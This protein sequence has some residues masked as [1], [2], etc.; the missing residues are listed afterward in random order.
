MSDAPVAGAGQSP[1]AA[2]P[3]AAEPAMLRGSFAGTCAACGAVAVMFGLAVIGMRLTDI[4]LMLVYV[5]VV[6]GLF[7]LWRVAE[8][9]APSVTLLLRGSQPV[10][11]RGLLACAI[12]YPLLSTDSY[13]LH[14]F[15]MAGLFA[16][17]ALGLNI[18]VGFAGLADFGFI[19]YYAIGAYTSALLDTRLGLNVWLC[20]PLAGITAAAA[21]L[22]VS[23]P[24]LRVSG[25]YL[26]LVTL[27]FAFIV[28]Q[29]ITNLDG[30]TGGTQGVFG[31][32]APILFG[33]DFHAPLRLWFVNLP[34]QA[35][36]YYLSLALLTLAAAGCVRLGR[37][38]WGRAWAAMRADEV[39]AQASGLDL[40]RLK[41]IAFATGAGLG[42][43]AGGVY[44]HM[45]GYLDP[46]SF[47]Y[48]DSIILLAMVALGNWRV[49]GVVGAAVLFTILPEKLRAFDDWRL[50][51]FGLALLT[52]ML[53]RG[54]RAALLAH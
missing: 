2:N 6:G 30:L 13:Q 17:M 15:A 29:M 40:T 34:Y 16:L 35:N 51:L 4:R 8:R 5:V 44:A 23:L 14:L 3:E 43:I 26:A 47:R 9:H 22:L 25:H 32:D 42:G 36:F 45:I 24:S 33:H 46:S 19:A 12:V 50:L 18:T 10:V 48:M 41:L 54:R 38:R 28:I 27:G 37:S 53:V 7:G 49:G 11:V 39:A 1:L 21:S 31:I 52:T 20:L